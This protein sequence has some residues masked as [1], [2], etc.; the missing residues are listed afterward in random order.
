MAQVFA[1]QQSDGHGLASE[2]GPGVDVILATPERHQVNIGKVI[3]VTKK[4]RLTA[5]SSLGYVVGISRNDHA[6]DSSHTKT[7]TGKDILS[8]INILSPELNYFMLKNQ[9]PFNR[10]LFLRT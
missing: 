2:P 1:G 5:V 8:K 3:V 6:C 10:E 7:V 9:V 4:D